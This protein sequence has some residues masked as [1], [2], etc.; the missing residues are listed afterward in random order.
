MNV[1][2][3]GGCGYIGAWLIPHLLAEGHKVTVFD[4]QH[5]GDGSLPKQN[6]S[7]TVIKGDVRDQKDF[8]S[9]CEGQEAVIY[10]AGITSND[11]CEKYPWLALSVNRL[12]FKHAIGIAMDSGVQRFIF[13]SSVAAYG[14]S[15]KDATETQELAPTTQYA[16]AKGYC[17][18]WLYFHKRLGFATTI[19]R[20]ASICGFSPRQRFDLT[21]NKMVYDAMAKGVITVNGGE[22][23]RSHVHIKDISDFYK[24]ILKAP[25]EKIAGEVFNVVAENQSVL[26]TAQLVASYLKAKVKIQPRSDNRSYTVDGT[27]AREVLGFTP[28]KRV[29]DAIKDLKIGFDSGYWQ[30]S[31]T[32]DAYWNVVHGL[33]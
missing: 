28:K 21:V 7:L 19:V 25:I 22:Q 32:N 1:L 26:E 6:D 29:A 8:A 15:E 16:K 12:G 31:E 30:D 9:A 11:M 27:K 18:W 13:A 4:A 2:V 10:L 5:F 14:S 17:E 20:S 33:S 23:K 3:P 24:L